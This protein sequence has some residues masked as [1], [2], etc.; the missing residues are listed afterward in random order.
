[1]LKIIGNIVTNGNI[2]TIHFRATPAVVISY[3]FGQCQQPQGVTALGA[4]FILMVLI[5]KF[6]EM[7]ILYQK[8]S[9]A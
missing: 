6:H 2:E 3:R 5:L 1:M 4:V 8:I 7:F 9:H